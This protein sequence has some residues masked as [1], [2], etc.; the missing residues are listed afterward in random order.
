MGAQTNE[1]EEETITI[2]ELVENEASSIL[3][4]HPALCVGDLTSSVVLHGPPK[5]M[6]GFFLQGG[7]SPL[8]VALSPL[9][10]QL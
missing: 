7:I 3:D 4:M 2:E 1:A 10:L 6:Q 5:S 9:N 8:E